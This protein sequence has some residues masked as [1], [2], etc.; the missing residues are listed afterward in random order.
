MSLMSC[1]DCNNLVSDQA[2]SCLNCGR[3]IKRTL[4]EHIRSRFESFKSN[5]KVFFWKTGQF[6]SEAV[7]VIGKVALFLFLAAVI[8]TITFLLKLLFV[9][10]GEMTLSNQTAMFS[11]SSALLLFAYCAIIDYTKNSRFLWLGTSAVILSTT[12]ILFAAEKAPKVFWTTLAETY[13]PA[14]W[15]T[16]L[17]VVLIKTF[18]KPAQQDSCNSQGIFTAQLS[19][20]K[21]TR[22]C[23]L[24]IFFISLLCQQAIQ[25]SSPNKGYKSPYLSSVKSKAA[26]TVMS[27]SKLKELSL[28]A[29]ELNELYKDDIAQEADFEFETVADAE[30]YARFM[31]E[32]K[33]SFAAA[34]AIPGSKS[35]KTA[36][37]LQAVAQ[38]RTASKSIAKKEQGS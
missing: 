9:A 19:L 8:S 14:I 21:H 11:V 37:R 26:S 18:A 20:R 22:Y 6:I 31:K 25:A 23:A 29:N 34:K 32:K 35:E 16:L 17:V 5:L 2:V 4:K 12:K 15:F 28:K 24:L 10:P 1:P 3:P 33:Y 30:A 7:A 36:K 13:Q 38:S 27:P